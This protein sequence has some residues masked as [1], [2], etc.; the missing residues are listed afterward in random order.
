MRPGFFLLHAPRPLKRS[1]FLLK[2]AGDDKG[3]SCSSKAKILYNHYGMTC[4]AQ[5]FAINVKGGCFMLYVL[6]CKDLPGEGLARRL[7]A[8]PDHLAYLDSL[9]E[10]V[11]AAGGLLSE[12]GTEPRGSLIIIEAGSLDEARAIAAADPYAKAGVFADVEVHPWRQAVG[13]VS[14]G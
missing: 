3:V 5:E 10:K 8:R 1:L 6:I 12:D 11:R 4:V 14:L 7:R 2:T 9:G 13:A